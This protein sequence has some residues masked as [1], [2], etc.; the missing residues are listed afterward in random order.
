MQNLILLYII[1][2]SNSDPVLVA[3]N[4]GTPKSCQ[5]EVGSRDYQK[6]RKE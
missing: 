4:L 3:G 1:I 5:E 2:F 6:V